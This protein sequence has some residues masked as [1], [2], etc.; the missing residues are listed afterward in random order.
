[1]QCI[2]PPTPCC[3]NRPWPVFKPASFRPAALNSLFNQCASKANHFHPAYSTR[4][5]S[6]D[7]PPSPGHRDVV[8][9]SAAA[10]GQF[11]D[12]SDGQHFWNDSQAVAQQ[13][14]AFLSAQY[15]PIALVCAL[16]LGAVNPSLGL[17]ASKMHIPALAT[18][19]IFTV[20]GLQL[21][22]KEAMSALTAQ[23]ECTARGGHAGRASQAAA[24]MLFLKKMWGS[25]ANGHKAEPRNVTGPVANELLRS[26]YY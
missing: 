4:S 26:A 25:W 22:R 8:V 1:M 3:S 6:T 19:G 18:F 23:R 14:K 9:T 16:T 2:C 24:C 10:A 7:P 5:K 15:L 20:Q 17:A 21:R 11:A 13:L 12:G